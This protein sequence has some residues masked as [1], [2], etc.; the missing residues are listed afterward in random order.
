MISRKESIEEENNEDD[1]KRKH[2]FQGNGLHIERH[3]RA[4][5]EIQI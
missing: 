3:K 5:W 1:N 2:K 4:I